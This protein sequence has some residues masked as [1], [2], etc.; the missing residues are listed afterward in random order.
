MKV[1]NIG[2]CNLD[3]VYALGHIVVEGETERIDSMEENT[4][5]S[6]NNAFVK[7]LDECI[8]NNLTSVTLSGF[9]KLIRYSYST[10][11]NLV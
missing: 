2:S 9:A 4:H 7:F 5:Y 1:L 3:Y 6:S 8:L 10:A 11:G